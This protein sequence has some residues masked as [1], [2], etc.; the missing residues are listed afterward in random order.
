MAPF[1][2]KTQENKKRIARNGTFFS[3]RKPF[4]RETL[5]IYRLMDL[6]LWPFFRAV[7]CGHFLEL[8]HLWARAATDDHEPWTCAPQSLETPRE[9]AIN[10]RSC[11]Q[12]APLL[13]DH[14]PYITLKK[15]S[16]QN[17]VFSRGWW[18][19]CARVRMCLGRSGLKMVS[20]YCLLF[21]DFSHSISLGP[22]LR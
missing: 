10:V 9:G 17:V 12:A 14:Q 20:L 19:N 18:T 5:V 11:H 8:S 13:G 15:A 4:L 22:R 16:N 2:P 7:F 1:L 6:M 21:P 3:A